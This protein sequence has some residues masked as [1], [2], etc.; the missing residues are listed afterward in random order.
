MRSDAFD[1]QPAPSAVR[2]RNHGA[3]AVAIE[4]S[5]G[6]PVWARAGSMV[7]YEGWIDLKPNP[8]EL[9]QFLVGR[10]TGEQVPLMLCEGDGTLYLADYGAYVIVLRLDDEKLTVN[11]PN[12]LAYDG[13]ITFTVQLAG[14]KARHTGHGLFNVALEGTGWVAITSRGTPLVLEP[15]VGSTVVDPQA[16]VA[17]TKGLTLDVRRAGLLSAAIGRGSGEEVQV[18]FRGQGKVVVQPSEDPKR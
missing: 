13:S 11:G 5:T 6:K 15:E 1:D 18:M 7:A 8:P 2:M 14:W 16:L 17:W 3:K 9:R 12:V 4:V 10:L